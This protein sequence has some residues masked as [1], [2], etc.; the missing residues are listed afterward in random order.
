MDDLGVA[1]ASLSHSLGG[2]DGAARGRDSAQKE[3]KK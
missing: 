1:G 3:K 2:V